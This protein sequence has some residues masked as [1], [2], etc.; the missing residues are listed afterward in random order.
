MIIIDAETGNIDDA[1][2]AACDYYLYSKRNC[3]SMNISDINIL[4]QKEISKEIE[5]AEL[6]NSQFL[7]LDINYLTVK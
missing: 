5:K 4:T 7:D 2:L 6:E 3:F 1:N